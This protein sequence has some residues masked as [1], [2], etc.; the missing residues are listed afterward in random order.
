MPLYLFMQCLTCGKSYKSQSGLTFHS[1]SKHNTTQ[2]K[3]EI[4]SKTFTRAANVARHIETVHN[5]AKTFPCRWCGKDFR[6][7]GGRDMHVASEHK[8]VR[9]G[10]PTCGKQFTRQASLNRHAANYCTSAAAPPAAN[11]HP[12]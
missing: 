8:A 6:S 5:H 2:Y 9:Y 1:K 7:T 10:C 4:C 12:S 11:R 3:C